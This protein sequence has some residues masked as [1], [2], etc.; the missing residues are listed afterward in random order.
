MAMP[1]F[2]PGGTGSGG[3]LATRYA[4]AVGSERLPLLCRCM[5]VEAAARME[6]LLDATTGIVVAF[7]V[8]PLGSMGSEEKGRRCSL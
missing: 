1:K 3:M 2:G 7:V 4:R 8:S 5:G 6:R